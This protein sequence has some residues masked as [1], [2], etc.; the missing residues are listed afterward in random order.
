MTRNRLIAA[1][2]GVLALL[3]LAA[4]GYDRSQQEKVA[5]GVT[6]GGVDIS[7]LTRAEAQMKL[8]SEI[9]EAVQKPVVVVHDGERRTLQPRRSRVAVDVP[10]MVDHAIEESNKGIFVVGA[11]RRISGADRN[12]AIPVE[13]TWSKPSVNRFVASVNR[14]FAENPQD[15]SLKYSAKGL[16]VKPARKGS[17]VRKARLNEQIVARLEDPTMTRRIKAPM[18]LKNA[19]VTT[20]AE[21]AKKYP[22]VVIVDRAGFKLRLYKKLKLDRTYPIAVGAAGHDTPTG[23]YAIQNKQENPSWHVPNSEWAGDLAGKVIPPGPDNPIVARWLG[24]ADGVGIHGTNSLGSIGSAASHGCIRMKPT[25]V[26][27]LFP[28]VPVGSPVYIS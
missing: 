4:F 28:L 1:V 10:G 2:A 19:A 14:S 3:L 25:D 9:E 21:L 13:I 26:I 8:E 27:A 17:V 20:R 16:G 22:T 15:A 23:I 5:N 7:G 12:L 18:R 11:A 6:V 24:I